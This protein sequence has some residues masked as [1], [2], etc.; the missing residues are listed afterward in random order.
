M[1]DT[2]EP[3]TYL[4]GESIDPLTTLCELATTVANERIAWADTDY[5]LTLPEFRMLDRAAKIL[6]LNARHVPLI[7]E[8]VLAKARE[9]G[10][11]RS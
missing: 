8:E 3:G 11:L 1:T 6:M 7:V 10:G 2:L 4:G 9:H 5:G